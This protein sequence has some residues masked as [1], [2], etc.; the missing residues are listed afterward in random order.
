[1]QSEGWKGK[2]RKLRGLIA[3]YLFG[4]G[5]LAYIVLTLFG[6]G[7]L[8]KNTIGALERQDKQTC[9]GQLGVSEKGATCHCNVRAVT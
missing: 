7:L 8:I 1:M 3:V 9:L 6:A 2:R 4:L 5:L